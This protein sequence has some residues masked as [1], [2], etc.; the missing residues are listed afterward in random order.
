MTRVG[1]GRMKGGWSR[2]VEKVGVEEVC[3]LSSPICGIVAN[4]DLWSL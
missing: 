3:G 4:R 1:I 2:M